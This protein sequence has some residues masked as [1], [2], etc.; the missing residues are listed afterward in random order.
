MKLLKRV[1]F[2]SFLCSFLLIWDSLKHRSNSQKINSLVVNLG[3]PP[4]NLNPHLVRFPREIFLISHLYEGLFRFGE[5]GSIIPGL[6]ERVSVSQDG[7]SYLI[8]LR[9]SLWSDGT[10]VTAYDFV[11]SWQ[12]VIRPGFRFPFFGF[13]LNWIKGVD[14]LNS[15]HADWSTVSLCADGD[16]CLSFTLKQPI[17]HFKHL[18]ALPIFFP[19]REDSDSSNVICNGP[20][21]VKSF[22]GFKSLLL[23]K[24]PFFWDAESVF[25]KEIQL[26]FLEEE[27]QLPLFESGEIDCI[28]FI[29]LYS[30]KDIERF[31]LNRQV[32]QSG[33]SVVCAMR[34]NLDERILSSKKIRQ[35]LSMAL[36]RKELVKTSE[37]I[38]PP[39]YRYFPLP[40]SDHLPFISL[41]E[42]PNEARRLFLEGLQEKG[43]EMSLFQGFSIC[44]LPF[45]RSFAQVIQQQ[46][47]KNLGIYVRII[48]LDS[49]DYFQRVSSGDFQLALSRFVSSY[50]DPYSLLDCFFHDRNMNWDSSYFRLLFQTGLSMEGEEKKAC[51]AEIERHI[52]DELP[53]IPLSF[54]SPPFLL[55]TGLIGVVSSPYLS[56]DF[57]RACWAK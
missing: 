29:S 21:R 35:A 46:L 19:V 55:Q 49:S 15:G 54:G 4:T 53:V 2:V 50:Q 56:L 22:D 36:D 33:S 6:A 57:S 30:E 20:F 44:C 12:K 26:L 11:R 42:D 39:S 17:H 51:I 52:L 1:L 8:G 14:Q 18:L 7:L 28:G 10:P 37:T 41:K 13:H 45:C 47:L 43:L 24:N 9:K 32:V 23:E 3:F 40:F 27:V 5:N 34:I 16:Y 31:S 48:L 25:L 38:T